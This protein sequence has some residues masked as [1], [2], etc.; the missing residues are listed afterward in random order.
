MAAPATLAGTAIREF[1]QSGCCVFCRLCCP[2]Q[3]GGLEEKC[4]PTTSLPSPCFCRFAIVQPMADRSRLEV[5]EEGLAILRSIRG[6][7]CPIAVIGPYRSGKVGLLAKWPW[8]QAG[9]IPGWHQSGR[10]PP[11]PA[12]NTRSALHPATPLQSFTLNQL[13]GVGCDEGFGVGH[14]RLTQTKGVWLW[15]EP[16]PVTLP[17][18]ETT[19]VRVLHVVVV[20]PIV[21]AGAAGCFKATSC[22][23]HPASTPSPP[24]LLAAAVYRYGGV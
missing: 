4:L 20:L 6:S 13:M 1:Y 7:V 22:P 21:C 17:N 11:A 18:G 9:V 5:Q 24:T 14:T 3:A 12:P 8:K 10:G 15:G 19:N 23:R 16:V 2:L